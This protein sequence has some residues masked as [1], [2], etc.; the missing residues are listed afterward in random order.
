MCTDTW[1]TCFGGRRRSH[2]KDRPQSSSQLSCWQLENVRSVMRQS[3]SRNVAIW[4]SEGSLPLV[5]SEVQFP[6]LWKLACA[7]TNALSCAK[8]AFVKRRARQNS[9][10]YSRYSGCEWRKSVFSEKRIMWK[11][12]LL[13]PVR[14]IRKFAGN[15]LTT[16]SIHHA[17]DQ[18]SSNRIIQRKTS[19]EPLI[20]R[21]KKYRRSCGYH[22]GI[23]GKAVQPATLQPKIF[24]EELYFCARRQKINQT[25]S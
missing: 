24:K 4:K 19:R 9:E 14:A 21:R 17:E 5:L 3:P 8:I 11:S 2:K 10:T 7:Q 22:Q 20:K 18:T 15:A 13:W 16:A 6:Q 1:F 12:F 23:I 25:G